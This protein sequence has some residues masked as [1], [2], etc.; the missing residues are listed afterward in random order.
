MPACGTATAGTVHKTAIIGRSG[1]PLSAIKSKGPV[2]PRTQ[3]M[4]GAIRDA[5]GCARGQS[6]RTNRQTTQTVSSARSRPHLC[7]R[8]DKTDCACFQR[9]TKGAHRLRFAARAP[10]GIYQID[11]LRCLTASVIKSASFDNARY[12]VPYIFSIDISPL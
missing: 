2:R 9:Q 8:A 11:K 10:C 6:T 4:P 3:A 1:P 12:L 5:R 7:E